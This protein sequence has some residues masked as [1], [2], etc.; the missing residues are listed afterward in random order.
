LS[1]ALSEGVPLTT[2]ALLARCG[3]GGGD[4]FHIVRRFE[5]LRAAFAADAA[6]GSRLPHAR[7]TT[8]RKNAGAADAEHGQ[9]AWRRRSKAAEVRT[10]CTRPA[11]CFRFVLHVLRAPVCSERDADALVFHAVHCRLRACCVRTGPGQLELAP[12]PRGFRRDLSGPAVPRGPCRSN[13]RCNSNN[14]RVTCHPQNA[15]GHIN[16]G[17]RALGVNIQ[18]TGF[19][20]NILFIYTGLLG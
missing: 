17:R 10:T 14:K 3:S 4:M 15:H 8:P 11:A 5:D 20:Q 1:G 18:T 6:D 7:P 19:G 16:E 2:R 9:V 12:A 13:G